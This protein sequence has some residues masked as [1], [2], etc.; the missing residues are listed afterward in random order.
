MAGMKGQD[1]EREDITALDAVQTVCRVISIHSIP[2]QIKSNQINSS[3]QD[4]RECGWWVEKL[5]DLH[6]SRLGWS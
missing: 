3:R 5:D 1:G 2:T 6:N 4:K